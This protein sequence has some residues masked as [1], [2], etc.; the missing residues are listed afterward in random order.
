MSGSSG[1]SPVMAMCTQSVGVPEQYQR[2]LPSFVTLSG[3]NSV[4]ELL[5]PLWFRSGAT[6][7]ISVRP[8]SARSRACRPSAR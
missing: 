1:N 8:S 7:M 6:S 5:A 3:S 4:S 2:F